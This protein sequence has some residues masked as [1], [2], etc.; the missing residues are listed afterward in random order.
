MAVERTT[1]DG[2]SADF[3]DLLERRAA[4]VRAPTAEE[5]LPPVAGLTALARLVQT[6]PQRTVEPPR[7]LIETMVADLDAA[8]SAHLNAILHAPEFQALE[9]SWRGLWLLVRTAE[10]DA[11]VKIKV[12]DI[13]KRELSR[14][15]RK[16]RGSAWDHSPIFRHI[17]EAEYGQF[18]GEPYGLLVG[19]FQFDHRPDDVALLG[20]V[21]RIAA[22]AHAPFIAAAAPS[23]LQMES[24]TEV[25]NPRELSRI[26]QTPEYT[27][28]RRLRE[29]EDTRY[30]GLCMPRFLARLPYGAATDPLDAFA[31]EEETEGSGID[32][33]L[34][35]NAAFAFGA[36]VARAFA[37]YGWCVRIRG[38]DRGGVVEGLPVLHHPSADGDVDR[39]TVTEICLSEKRDAE[40]ASCGL[41]ALV[42][43][44]NSDVAAFVS[45]QSLQKPPVYEDAAATVNANLSARLPYL[46]ACCRF[47]HYLKCMVR[48]K[49]G[50]A[51]TGAQT[52]GW[53][54]GWLIKYIDGSPATSTD[55]FKAAHPLADARVAVTER[56]DL[57]G[58]FEAK[59]LLRPHYQ[60]EGLS[61]M[62]RLSSRM[63]AL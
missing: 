46:F 60:L 50:T 9:A 58:T 61:V 62:L 10:S 33:L 35:S 56:D 55:E 18:G 5:E 31:F 53:L 15:L 17:Y 11:G 3:A 48:D 7:R 36:N 44:K 40:L 41:I 39:R 12:L 57:P 30:L 34:W 13:S 21:A 8:L 22:A 6:D 54:S 20:D 25:A 4:T 14:T 27:A 47:A 2:A 43:R 38:V 37:T 52:A 45:A 29:E 26:L 32:R 49:V 23:L 24:W 16:F 19:D 42:H 63:S 1:A 28:W 51:M 59:F